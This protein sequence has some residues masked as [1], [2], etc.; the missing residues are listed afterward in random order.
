MGLLLVLGDT[1]PPTNTEKSLDGYAGSVQ[2]G[3]VA[4]S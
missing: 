4:F 1:A 2:R 3:R